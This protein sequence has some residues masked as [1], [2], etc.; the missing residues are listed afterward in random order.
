M[1]NPFARQKLQPQWPERT[2]RPRVLYENADGALEW[3]VTKALQNVGYDTAVCGGPT[4]LPGGRCRLEHEGRCALAEGADVIVCGLGLGTHGRPVVA[5]L[6]QCLPTTPIVVEAM[7][8]D[9]EHH[10]DFLEGCQVVSRFASAQTLVSAVASAL[11]SAT[12]T[13]KS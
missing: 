12:P 9:V 8:V 11:D 3:V 7:P 1:R 6:K 4:Q 10:P 5:S 2:G 13:L